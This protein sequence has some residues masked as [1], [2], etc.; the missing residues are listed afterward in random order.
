MRN[1]RSRVTQRDEPSRHKR[2]QKLRKEF[3]VL[4]L[5]MRVVRVHNARPAT[6]NFTRRDAEKTVWFEAVDG[7]RACCK[8]RGPV[9]LGRSGRTLNGPSGSEKRSRHGV[10]G[11]EI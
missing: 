2:Q 10:D 3:F 7:S 11:I 1:T 9:V 6:V 8:M 5:P 4:P